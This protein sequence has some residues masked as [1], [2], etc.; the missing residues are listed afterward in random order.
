MPL[1]HRPHKLFFDNLGVKLGY[2]CL[3]DWYNVTTK[4]IYQNGGQLIL[5]ARYNGSPSWALQVVYP[6]H[7]WQLEKFTHKPQRFWM[8][9][10]TFNH[11][12]FFDWLMKQLGYKCMEDWYNVTVEDIYNDGGKDCLSY[13]QRFS[14][15][16]IAN[17]VS[18][19]QLDVVEVQN[20]TTWLLGQ[21]YQRFQRSNRID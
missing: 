14:F 15:F 7:N 9:T 19:T 10:E 4:D 6:H 21:G 3:D 13:L 16:G 17:S 18:R 12:K 8:S 2:K 20:S 5:S 11:Q 1:I